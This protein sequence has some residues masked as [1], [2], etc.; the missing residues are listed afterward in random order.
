VLLIEDIRGATTP[1]QIAG[2]TADEARRILSSLIPLHVEYWG[3]AELHELHWLPPMN[4][5]VYKGAQA[6]GDARWP[7]FVE[8]FGDRIDDEMLATLRTAIDHYPELLDFQ[9]TIGAPTFTHTD[10]RAENYLFAG[11][12]GEDVTVVDF[13]LSTRHWGMWDVAN[14]LGGSMEPA[15]RRAHEADL[16]AWY[17]DEVTAAGVDD[18]TLEQAMLEYRFCL[19]Q[20]AVAAVMVSDLQGGNDRGV[21]LL[22]RLFLR[23]I[24]AAHDHDVHELLPHFTPQR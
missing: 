9:V 11:R 13:Q 18:Y 10:C 19:L 2:I 4:N 1:D 22:E 12:E 17:V 23:P 21:E 24:E 7:D 3:S 20:Q 5:D 15:V 6:L 14:L 16:V 8:R